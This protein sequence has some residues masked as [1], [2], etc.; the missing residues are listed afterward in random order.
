ML[1]VRI[2]RGLRLHLTELGFVR[3]EQ[4]LFEPP[5]PTKECY[6]DLHFAQRTDLLQKEAKFVAENWTDLKK[7]FASGTDVVPQRISPRLEIIKAGTWQSRLFRMATLC[8]SV[9]VSHGYGR[10]MRFLVWDDS[11]GKLIGLAALGD[12]VFNMRVRDTWIGWSLKQREQKLVNVLDAY[13]LGA[14]PP[15]NMLLGTKLIASLLATQE[16]KDLFAKRYGRTKGIISKK[17]KRAELCLITTTSSLGR[18][19]V[20]NRVRLN[21]RNILSSIGYTSGWGHFH[22]PDKLFALMREYL[23]AASDDYASNHRFG[24]GPNWKMR[25]VRKVLSLIGMDPDLM[26]HGIAREVFV[27]PLASNAQAF[28]SDNDPEPDFAGLPRSGEVAA[29]ALTRWVIPRAER[30]PDFKNWRVADTHA[31]ICPSGKSEAKMLIAK[32]A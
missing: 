14:I 3:N 10:R 26:R 11:N 22:I 7:Y 28:L 19:S 5:E 9:P 8:W 21:G 23:K 27:C 30:K 25:A 24:D 15:Y 18:S 20:Y 6:R 17:R 12:P 32:T 31:L 2:K 16:V 29:A 13:V 4:G 1:A